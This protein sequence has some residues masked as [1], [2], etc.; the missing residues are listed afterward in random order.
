MDPNAQLLVSLTQI[1][2]CVQNSTLQHIEESGCRD[3]K[4]MCLNEDLLQVLVYD[5]L[6]KCEPHDQNQ[7]LEV[8]QQLCQSVV[9]SLN[10]S[11]Q[12][13]I[14]AIV[15]VMTVV[16]TLSVILRLLGR[17]VSAAQYGADDYLIVVALILTYGLNVNEII[18]VHFGFGRH[19]LMLSLDHISKFLLNDWTI[20]IIFACAIT[21]TRFSL[22]VFYHRIF[23]VKRFTVVAIITGC[24]LIAWWIGF[25]FAIV[26]SCRPTESFWN[27][28]LIDHCVNEHTLSWGVTGSEMAVNVIML[29]LPIPWLWHLRLACTKKLALIGLFMLGCFVCI[30][31]VVRIPL[32]AELQQTDAS[33]TLVP[34]GVWIIVECNIGVASVCLP[35]MRPLISLDLATLIDHLPFS[36]SRRTASPC[37]DEEANSSGLPSLGK[38]CNEKP[39]DGPCPDLI[40]P[41]H[42][43]RHISQCQAHPPKPVPGGVHR[44]V[45]THRSR[46]ESGM[47][48]YAT[49]DK[50]KPSPM[51][52][53]DLASEKRLTSSLMD[54]PPQTLHNLKRKT[55]PTTTEP[56][57][58]NHPPAKLR[59]SSTDQNNPSSSRAQPLSMN[60]PPPKP[61]PISTFQNNPTSRRAPP[62]SMNPPPPKPPP[63]STA[64]GHLSSTKAKPLP[65]TLH[66]SHPPRTSMTAPKPPPPPPKPNRATRPPTNPI[67]PPRKHQSQRPHRLSE[68]EMNERYARWYQG[69]GSE[70]GRG[71]W[72]VGIVSPGSGNSGGGGGGGSGGAGLN[73]SHGRSVSDDHNTKKTERRN[74]WEIEG[75]IGKESRSKG[76]GKTRGSEIGIGVPKSRLSS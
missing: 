48:D 40:H 49:N 15:A 75:L 17:R 1:P 13:E 2:T 41:G 69:R 71:F 36:K 64:K 72:S 39:Y 57:S 63:P 7:A 70:I 20:Q 32:L 65:K 28:A 52:E 60:P 26:F 76:K 66:P 58:M 53:A 29:V 8:S 43:Y 21:V 38:I 33:W 62:L 61:K 30:S 45:Q 27:K 16:S 47:L 23:P 12:T 37:T 56:L 9:P 46:I 74:P 6:R 68:E 59:P 10:D 55:Y 51:A 18:A 34:A 11:R 54:P 35:L 50:S 44:D 73:A 5:L 19:Q 31:C 4:C 14:V 67:E 25:I 3:V 22:L 42:K 24:I